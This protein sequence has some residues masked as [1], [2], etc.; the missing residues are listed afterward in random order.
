MAS[1]ETAS[2][3]SLPT[4][5]FYYY[6][7]INIKEIIWSF[8]GCLL[9]FSVEQ[10]LLNQWLYNFLIQFCI[11]LQWEHF[12]QTSQFS[13]LT[14]SSLHWPNYFNKQLNWNAGLYLNFNLIVYSS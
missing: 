12:N 3:K 1:L 6:E 4:Q 7:F 13:W 10:F 9:T 5:D 8:S 14:C 2:Q 11:H